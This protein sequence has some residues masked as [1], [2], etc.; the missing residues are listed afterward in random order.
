MTL[1]QL[2]IC[3]ITNCQSL[4]K[5]TFVSYKHKKMAASISSKLDEVKSE[6]P[7]IV[8]EHLEHHPFDNVSEGVKYELLAQR[9]SKL[10]LPLN[11]INFVHFSNFNIFLCIHLPKHFLLIILFYQTWIC[12]LSDSHFSIIKKTNLYM[13]WMVDN[14]P[15]IS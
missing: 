12:F 9:V 10:P 11:C 3:I 6:G 2:S 8:L 15:F 13:F 4:D 7:N 1:M 14:K 5:F